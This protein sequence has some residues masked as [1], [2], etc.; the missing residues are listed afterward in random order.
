MPRS[1]KPRSTDAGWGSR[2]MPATASTTGTSC[3]SSPSRRFRNSASASPSSPGPPSSA[4]K[5]REGDEAASRSADNRHGRPHR[6]RTASSRDIEALGEIGQDPQGRD[7][8]A[9]FQQGRPRSPRLAQDA[10]PGRRFGIPAGRRGQHLR[11]YGRRRKSRH[12]RI[13]YRHGAQRRPVRRGHRRPGRPGVPEADPRIQRPPGQ[14]PEVVSFTDEEGNLVGDFLGSRAFMGLL[15]EE[16]VRRGRT[17]FGRPLAEVLKA[18]DITI[19]GMLAAGKA[20]PE[21]EAY[22]ELHIEQGP[23]LET[24]E[25]PIG[26]VDS[27][28][29]KRYWWCS[30]SGRASPRGNDAARAPAGRLPG[31]GRF[32]P[33]EH[34][35]RGRVALRKPGHDRQGGRPSGGLQHRPRPGGILARF[36]ERLAGDASGP[37]QGA[38]VA[39]RGSRLIERP[40]FL[41]ETHGRDGTR[42]DAGEDDGTPGGGVRRP[43]LSV[44]APSQRGRARRPDPGS[45]AAIRA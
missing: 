6:H 20:K 11:P 4:S 43:R 2:S 33:E 12:G 26:L 18:T 44:P 31:A 28:A 14:A 35:A 15:D 36:Q 19:E 16:A 9:L 23:V 22:V 39:G 37:G 10:D 29:G 41:L 32:R 27:I 17:S 38:E 30:F 5:G 34:A 13:P 7:Q 21:V 8:P 42:Q 25:I 24:E 1:G 40:C 45:P 3:R